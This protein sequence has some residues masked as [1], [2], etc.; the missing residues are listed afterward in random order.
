LASLLARTTP[1]TAGTQK[2][3]PEDAELTQL[4]IDA[5]TANP[6]QPRQVFDPQEME[7]LTQSIRAN[8]ILQPLVVRALPD[9]FQLIAGERRWRAARAA[10]L[11]KVPAVVR[12]GISDL[13]MLGLSL[14]ENIQRDDLNPIESARGYRRLID[15][16]SLTQDQIA[17]RIGKSRS[18][19][20]NTLRLLDLPAEV[21]DMVEH[22]AISAGHARA[23]LALPSKA[24]QVDLAQRAAD[25]KLSVRALEQMIYGEPKERPRDK[26]TPEPYDPGPHIRSLQDTLSEFFGTKVIINEKKRRGSIVIEF[27]SNDDFERILSRVGIEL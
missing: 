25:E 19:V 26:P 4:E 7:D 13:E 2:E 11:K 1:D 20:A 15:E 8:G 10:G 22:N 9:T 23:L 14:L 27:Y 16:F 17:K 21:Q 3:A 6:Y 24:H 12:R 18:G 5:I